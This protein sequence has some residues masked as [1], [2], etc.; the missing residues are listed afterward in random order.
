[1]KDI[2]HG[3]LPDERPP[4]GKLFVFA[5]QQILVM[6][7]ATVLVA[8]LTGFHV[9]TTIFASGFAT[10]CFIFITKGKI[11]LY[12]GSSFSYIAAIVGITGAKFGVVA[13]DALISAAQFGIIMSGLVSILAGIVVSRFGLDKIEKVLPP[14]VT[15]SIAIVNLPGGNARAVVRRMGAAGVRQ[16]VDVIHFLRGQ[17][18]WRRRQPDIAIAVALHQRPRIAGIGFLVQHAGGARV[19]LGIG[20]HLFVRR[21]ADHD[22][23]AGHAAFVG[24]CRDRRRALRSSLPAASKADTPRRAH[25]RNPDR[26]RWRRR[27]APSRLVPARHCRKAATR[28][29]NP[30]GSS[31][32]LCRT[33]SRNVRC[34]GA[35]PRCRQAPPARRERLP[36]NAARKPS[37]RDRD[38]CRPRRSVC[39]HRR[40]A[41]AVGGVAVDHGIHVPGGDAE[42]QVRP[43]QRAERVCRMP[44]GLRNDAHAETMC[45]QEPPDYRH[46]EAR[47]IDVGITGDDDHI[48]GIPAQRVHFRPRHRQ[49]RRRFLVPDFPIRRNGFWRRDHDAANSTKAAAKARPGAGLRDWRITD[50]Y[51]P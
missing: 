35:R 47:V 29:W 23:I 48:A 4:L 1:M 45:L 13:P 21:Q 39:R 30:S 46:A 14:S 28:P 38:V 44:I 32:G 42:E 50:I 51:Y 16:F 22:M 18:N 6:F 40:A 12:Y 27:D 8:L 10:L 41:S 31:G 15:G 20:R 11:P 25:P 7:P 19:S 33:S 36:G 9:S 49:E 43:P 37:R 3:Y 17:R 2:V 5:L 34:A 26:S 24:T